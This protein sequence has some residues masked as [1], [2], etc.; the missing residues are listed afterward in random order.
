MSKSA[1]DHLKDRDAIM[2]NSTP[3]KCPQCGMSFI[4][5][6]QTF[7]MVSPDGDGFI[8]SGDAYF[9]RSCPVVVLE[10]E[11]FDAM[12][13]MAGARRY[14]ITGFVD[15]DAV[16]KE[17]RDELLGEEDNPIP[18]IPFASRS[19]SLPTVPQQ[20][21]LPGLPSQK[22]SLPPYPKISRNAPCPC[23]SGKKYKK[24]C[25]IASPKYGY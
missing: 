2:M 23:G 19:K 22:E 8:T 15:L 1:N 14:S 25:G 6:H 10:K 16:P 9:C 20:Q 13:E 12:A 24:C 7:L 11:H 4:Q 17:K 5:Q 3:K 18:V 21:N